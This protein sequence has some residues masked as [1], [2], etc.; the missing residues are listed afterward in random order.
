MSRNIAVIVA[1]GKGARSG[2]S[3][4]KQFVPLLGRPIL[5]WSA[6]CFATHHKIHK[7]VIVVSDGQ[8]E[9]ASEIVSEIDGVQIVQGGAER[10]DSVRA[11][12]AAIDGE[13]DDVVLIHDAARPGLTHAVIDDLL[14]A[15][16]DSQAAAPAVPVAD[17]LK[18]KGETGLESVDRKDLFRV[19][20]P[21]AFHFGAIIKAH[22]ASSGQNLVDDIEAAQKA[23]L[24]IELT[25]GDP[26]LMKVTYPEDFEMAERLLG[27]KGAPRIGSGYD[28]HAFEPG[29]SVH[30]CGKEIEHSASLRG[31]SDADVA[32]HAVTDAILGALSAGDIG[33][34]FPP[35]DNR[36]KGEPSST[37][38]MHAGK[39]AKENG[40]SISNLDITIICEAPKIKPHREDMRAN[41]AKI[42]GLDIE[43]VSV[44]ATTTEGL[45]FTG[46]R[47][48]VAAQAVV[49]LIPNPTPVME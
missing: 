23:G 29:D 45:G 40:F 34:H 47:E 28:V 44:K 30:L 41:T 27:R 16:Q 39:L 31:H 9:T 4:P 10:S 3:V 15:L 48:G 17:A 22:E 24:A 5:A 13:T 19:Q 32:W 42:L 46:R 11:A 14:S 7:V 33:D 43:Q 8:E 1:A 18:I 6:Y 36:W 20:T 35:S 49:L 37:F 2:Q 26:R 25:A 12:L 38:L 21:Q